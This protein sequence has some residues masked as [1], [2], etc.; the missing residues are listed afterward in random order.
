MEMDD[1]LTKVQGKPITVNDVVDHLKVSGIFRNTIYYLIEIEVIRIE[2]ARRKIIVTP[3]DVEAGLAEK[4]QYM[5]LTDPSEMNKHFRRN[6]IRL[7]QWKQSVADEILRRKL[8]DAIAGDQEIDDYFAKNSEQL[9]MLCVGRIVCKERPQIEAI[10]SQV[11]SGEEEFATLARKHSQEQ[12]SRIAGGHLGCFKQGMLP[13]EIDQALFS[14]GENQIFGP[15]QQNGF[16]ALYRI[17]EVIREELNKAAKGHIAD[18]LFAE[19]LHHKVV[20]ARP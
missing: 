4:R 3:D 7:E 9:R 10:K 19:W 8:K 2:A 20:T 5:G 13:P 1:V 12:T 18:K 17:E 6:G 16:W 14:A 11:L 15:F